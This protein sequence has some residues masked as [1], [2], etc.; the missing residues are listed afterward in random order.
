MI[1]LN[2]L[3]IQNWKDTT[4]LHSHRNM[5]E[6]SLFEIC[7]SRYFH[8]VD[9]TGKLSW[10][11]TC[12]TLYSFHVATRLAVDISKLL[13]KLMIVVRAGANV[14]YKLHKRRKLMQIDM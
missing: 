5:E 9:E 4:Q 11:A 12:P 7:I 10:E 13:H 3:L 1:V 8:I 6:L 2:R 14:R